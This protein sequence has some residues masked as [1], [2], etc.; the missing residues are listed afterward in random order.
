VPEPVLVEDRERL[1]SERRVIRDEPCEP[2]DDR[3]LQ[4][5]GLDV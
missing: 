3:P 1:A 4:V 2:P 5:R